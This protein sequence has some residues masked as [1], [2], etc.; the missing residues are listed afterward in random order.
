MKGREQ[1][2]TFEKMSAVNHLEDDCYYVNLQ[3]ARS[4]GG[5]EIKKAYRKLALVWHPGTRSSL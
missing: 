5:K 4:A 3:V 2:R 1:E